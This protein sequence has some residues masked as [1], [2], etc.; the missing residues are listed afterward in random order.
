MS[1][2]PQAFKAA[3]ARWASGV[4]I[5]TTCQ[6]AAPLGMTASSFTSVGLQPPQVLV[7]VNCE[8][9]THT[10][11]A[12]SGYFAVNLLA[13][14]QVE[15][16]MRFAGQ[17]PEVTSRFEG[18]GYTTARTGAPILPGVLAWLDCR[19]RHAF[20]GGDHTIFVGDVEAC[21]AHGDG[22]P[23]LYYNRNWRQLEEVA[24]KSTV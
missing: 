24:L 20:N 10:A 15:W 12:A 8:A 21:G 17:R 9:H 7:C 22:A 4:T 13:V 23:L 11:I 14:E 16:G 6:S 2:E 3:M 18:I 5:V 1:I 19:V